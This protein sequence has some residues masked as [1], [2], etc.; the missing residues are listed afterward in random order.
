MFSSLVEFGRFSVRCLMILEEI[1]RFSKS[2]LIW[3]VN[4]LRFSDFK[5]Y[6][7]NEFIRVSFSV[8]SISF[9]ARVLAIF[10]FCVCKI[11]R[12]IAVI[13]AAIN[14]AEVG[15]KMNERTEILFG[16]IRFWMFILSEP[17]NQQAG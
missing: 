10:Y 12:G 17:H 16:G 8:Y 9:W 15:L 4:A 5:E 14:T 6:S 2:E 13:I 7:F 3:L 11:G 1:P